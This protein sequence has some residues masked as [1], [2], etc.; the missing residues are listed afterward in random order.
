MSR[1][2]PG[3]AALQ[4]A[5]AHTQAAGCRK[6]EAVS[7]GD[8]RVMTAIGWVVAVGL[9]V[10]YVPPAGAVMVCRS[11]CRKLRALAWRTSRRRRT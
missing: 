7:A 2:T 8:H 10:F 1:Q 11:A 9:V 4:V 6:H 3:A 5:S